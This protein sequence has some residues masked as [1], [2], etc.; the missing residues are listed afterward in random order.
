MKEN[1]PAGSGLLIDPKELARIQA[2]CRERRA[3]L[4]ATGMLPPLRL[5][6]GCLPIAPGASEGAFA[7]LPASL[8]VG[9]A[10]RFAAAVAEMP[11]KVRA[12]FEYEEPVVS[13]RQLESDQDRL[14]RQAR[15]SFGGWPGT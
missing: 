6:P 11:P 5:A 2:A 8:P 12:F 10:E 9:E 1:D 13:S 7:A 14:E 15:T 3:Q 4:E